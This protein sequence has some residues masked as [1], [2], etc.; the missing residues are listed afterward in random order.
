MKYFN[1]ID[2]VYEPI[3]VFVDQRIDRDQF[4]D[5]AKETDVDHE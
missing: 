5:F 2:D 1:G 4:D 3:R